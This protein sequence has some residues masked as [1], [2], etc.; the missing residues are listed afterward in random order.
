[1]SAS[2][3]SDAQEKAKAW[4]RTAKRRDAKILAAIAQITL[5]TR[6]AD[7]GTTL[8]VVAKAAGWT[9]DDLLRIQ[10]AMNASPMPHHP[11]AKH[12]RKMK[13]ETIANAIRS[14]D[15][16]SSYPPSDDDAPAACPALYG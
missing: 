8:F 10:K 16:L 5:T 9:K 3:P 7:S 11:S 1:M 2:A 12:E 4:R 6:P 13:N 14:L 15:L